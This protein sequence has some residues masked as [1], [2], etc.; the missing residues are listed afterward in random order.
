[1]TS[2]PASPS[3]G[4]SA[5]A[6]SPPLIPETEIRDLGFGAVVAR[7]SRHRLLN[8]NGSFNVARMGLGWLESLS[9]Y[10]SLLT[11]TWPRF[12]GVVVACYVLIN[13]V[14]ALLFVALGPGALQGPLMGVDGRG[15]TIFRAFFF[16]VET[17]G[18]IGYGNIVPVGV[19]AHT[20][21]TVEALFGLLGVALAT[22]VIFAR[23]S[24]PTARIRFSDT[25]IVAPY[26]G[27]T[28]LEFRIANERTNQI[29]EL[30]AKVLFSR[31]VP[32]PSGSSRTFAELVLE[33]TSVTFFP[34]TWT[35]VHPIT[36]T[37]PLYGLTPRDMADTNAEVL[38]L[39]SGIDETFSQTVH[40]RSSYKPEEIVWNARFSDLFNRKSDGAELT[41]DISRLS[42]IDRLDAGA[43]A[44]R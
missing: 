13:A 19:V 37:S 2:P 7:E 23:F 28:A 40:A 34:L 4:A 31:F 41:V 24:R 36:E 29:I 21:V 8:R 38:I 27:I 43:G 14:F 12:L 18:T 20:L 42:W 17:F 30:Q 32:T 33:R 22:G 11:M 35:I 26:R 3:A 9:P 39:L 25:A 10:H 15:G 1:M 44:A 6:I 16:S 5:S